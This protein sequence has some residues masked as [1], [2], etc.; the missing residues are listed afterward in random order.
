MNMCFLEH[1]YV[2]PEME[3]ITFCSCWQANDEVGVIFLTCNE[4]SRRRRRTTRYSGATVP[5]ASVGL[6]QRLLA[7]EDTVSQR[8]AAYYI[9]NEGSM[10]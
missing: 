3:R 2:R 9:L 7:R 4:C 5:P 1:R 8:A 10:V 6:A